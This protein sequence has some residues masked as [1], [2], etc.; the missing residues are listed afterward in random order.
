LTL[1]TLVLSVSLYT[2][3]LPIIE[4]LYPYILRSYSGYNANGDVFS[5]SLLVV[6]EISGRLCIFL[7]TIEEVMSGNFSYEFVKFEL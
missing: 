5:R 1:L 7:S 6:I 4:R 2:V 3:S